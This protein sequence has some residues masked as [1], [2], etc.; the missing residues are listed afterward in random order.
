MKVIVLGAGMIG[1]VMAV[2]LARDFDV[3]CA[4]INH[5]ALHSLQQ[6]HG[7]KTILC[8]F[9]HAH[10][11]TQLIRTFDLVI[12]AVP[13]YLGFGVLKTV[14]ETE[15][16]LVDISFFPE[17]AFLLDGRAVEKNVLAVIDCG[18]AP[19]YCNMVAGHYSSLMKIESYECLVGGLPCHPQPPFY[20]KAPFSPA[21]V[22]EEYLRPV[23]MKQSGQIIV[24]EALSDCES[25]YFPEYGTFEAFN[26]D[27]LR[28]LLHT[29]PEIKE[30][31]E[32]TLRYPG[33]ASLMD[34]LRKAGFFGEEKIQIDDRL[35]SP[36]VVT[37]ALLARQWQYQAG[38]EDFTL[39]S[40]TLQGEEEG[41][42]K[43]IICT[44]YDRYH[45]PTATMSMARTT[46]YTATAVVRLIALQKINGK[47][48]CPPEFIGKQPACF[49]FVTDYL[50]EKGISIRFDEKPL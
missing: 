18:I 44:L 5:A 13:G 31:K 34:T 20:Y 46:A 24:K 9:N 2:D 19:G 36:R 14:I 33:H 6:Q 30:M 29:L 4:D 39:M 41:Q 27:G 7:I 11:I 37:T 32:K 1:R 43:Q 38:E 28:T 45:H 21:D 50:M 42:R 3:T 17:D 22:I 26:T 49:K 8:D 47:G 35:V 40:V 12:G 25:V 23:R 10:E 16:N 48:I 15:K